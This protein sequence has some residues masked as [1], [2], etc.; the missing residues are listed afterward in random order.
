MN[1]ALM[2]AALMNTAA[3]LEVVRRGATRLVL[4]VVV[5][6]GLL[7]APS[8]AEAGE[9]EPDE[10]PRVLL[11][12]LPT[13]SWDEVQGH[14]LPHLEGLFERSAVASLSVRGIR[15]TTD[16][17]D[18]Y[19]TMG[20]GGR[21]RG[22]VAAVGAAYEVDERVAGEGDG[23]GDPAGEVF[24]RRT[25]VDAPD[26]GL[27]SIAGPAIVSRNRGL[28][29]DTVIGALGATLETASIDRA[30]VANAD[31]TDAGRVD[32]RAAVLGLADL[33]GAVPD[34]AVGD[35][36]SVPD[37]EAAGGLRL[38]PEAVVEAAA[39]ALDREGVVLMVEA[40]DLVRVDAEAGATTSLQTA[41]L[42]AEALQ[43]TDHLVGELLS[44]VDPERDAVL[45]VAPWHRAGRPH[46]T[47]AAMRAPGVEPGLMETASTR[48]TGVVTL[49]DVA[50][51]VLDLVGVRVPSSMEGTPF[52]RTAGGG[53]WEERLDDLVREDEA[54]RFRDR[55]VAPLATAFVVVQLVLWLVAAVALRR[56][57]WLLR[58]VAWTAL[59]TLVFLSA[60][61]WAGLL[62]FERW[63]T[64]W[65]VAFLVG[66]SLLVGFTLPALLRRHPLDPLMAALTIVVGT[67]VVDI[68]LLGG[69][70]Q[71][72]TPFGY[73]PTVGG[74][75]AGLGNL[76]FGQLA[77][78]SIVL[79]G[80]VTHRLRIGRD[81]ADRLPV[82]AAGLILAGAVVVD[83]APMWGSDVGGVLALLPGGALTVYLL[84]GRRVRITTVVWAGLASVVAVV[85]FGALDL[86]RPVERRTHLG[87]LF[88]SIGE[89]GVSAFNTVVVR[90]L[91]A[92]FSVLNRSVWTLMLPVVAAFVIYLLWKAPS[93]LRRIEHTLPERDAIV[94]GFAVTAVLGFA[95]ND[96][97]IAIPGVMLGVLNAALVHE[98]AVEAGILGGQDP[99]D[100]E[101]SGDDPPADGDGDG[102][103]DRDRDGDVGDAAEEVVAR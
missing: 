36:L 89:D 97:G 70:M 18:G 84:Q 90:K 56:S 19:T 10:V 78:G 23:E 71:L 43:R 100:G 74:R 28:P 49:V 48:R 65:Y 40:S 87:R 6:A 53:T 42:R 46:L 72:S 29:Y 24:S 81:P 12:S 77:A 15:T 98:L 41:A 86:A 59:A 4:L 80:L 62:P 68:V 3:H 22:P 13:L 103:G 95:L 5:A 93:L 50:P 73:S 11:L 69:T 37:P 35:A 38:D 99:S 94:A 32:D 26:G 34:G 1:A 17:G 51:T 44:L 76:A 47:V 64:G 61:Y 75:F 33:V 30:V 55:L 25:G 21:A 85:V 92:N 31:R 20:A 8:V 102:D 60:T 79:A 7:G 101:R 58:Q 54:S 63:G 66:I 2:N 45:A 16:A 91:D 57:R 52:V 88:E 83:G 9:Q 82:L 27:V 39:E 14:D 67:L 96:S